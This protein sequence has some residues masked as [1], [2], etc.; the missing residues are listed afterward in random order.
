MEKLQ[1]NIAMIE[2]ISIFIRIVLHRQMTVHYTHFIT[3]S[4]R[5]E[6]KIRLKIKL[7]AMKLRH[8]EYLRELSQYYITFQILIIQ[9]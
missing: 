3:I 7:H 9:Y 2:S 6:R 4:I 5:I 1:S 8:L